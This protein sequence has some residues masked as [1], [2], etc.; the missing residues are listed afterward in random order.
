ML[1]GKT[2]TIK[3]ATNHTLNEKTGTI[4]D[5]TKHTITLQT[6]EKTIK[7]IKTHIITIEE[8]HGKTKNGKESPDG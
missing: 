3:E 8:H 1:I 7:I 6:K 2:I 4:I 5:E